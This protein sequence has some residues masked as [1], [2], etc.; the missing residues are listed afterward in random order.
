VGQRRL[1]IKQALSVKTQNIGNN[2]D[3]YDRES[4]VSGVNE[5]LEIIPQEPKV[6]DKKFIE[7]L[8]GD[9]IERLNL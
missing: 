9:N 3:S 8:S 7:E 6:T 5:H 1:L 4:S 2:N